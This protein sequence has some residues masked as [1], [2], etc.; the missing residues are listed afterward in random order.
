VALFDP[1]PVLWQLF[2]PGSF[3]S[4]F[5]RMSGPALPF[6]AMILAGGM[7]KRLRP[8]VSDR[9]KP[10]A[11]VEEQ[12]F[13]EVLIRTIARKGVK[14]FVL[15]TG[16]LSEMIEDHF[17]AVIVPGVSIVFSR[18]D[19]PLGTGGAVKN[20]EAHATEPTLLVNGDT[21]FDADV[22]RLYRFHK[23][24][25]PLVTLSLRLVDD[26]SRYGSVMMDDTGL[27]T[28][29]REKAETRGSP[30]LINA[31]LSLLSLEFI[32]ALPAGRSFSME[33]EV[34]PL[35]AGSGR[36]AGLRQDGAFFDI[37]TP[38]SYE[39]FKSYVRNRKHSP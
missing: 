37:G 10:L 38:E 15:L 30:G 19:T 24:K 14:R 20:A 9:P 18:E 27:V 13:L 31:G 3:S 32:S 16:Y 17:N 11:A 4:E 26:A 23:E 34:F 7:G 8:V 1:T 35:I 5:L 39:Q 33:Q 25:S 22:D 29:F 21:F 12:P 36:M 6:S 28:G 2:E